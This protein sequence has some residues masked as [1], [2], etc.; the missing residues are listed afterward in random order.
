M[1]N[2]V[3]AGILIVI[4]SLSIRKIVIEKKKGVKCIGCPQSGSKSSSQ[5]CSCHKTVQ[6]Q[7]KENIK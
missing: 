6:F 1:E 3:V 5:N 2:F 7:K 4:L